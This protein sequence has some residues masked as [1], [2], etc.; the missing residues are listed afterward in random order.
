MSHIQYVD[1]LI[2]EYLLYRG[3]SGTVKMFDSELKVDKDKSFRV[4]KIVDQLTQ[5]IYAYDLTSLREL[6]SHLDQRMFSKLEHNFIPAVRKLEN[7]VLK[8]YL[9]N[10]VLSGKPD[11]VTEFFAR[12]T[13]ELIGQPEWKEWFILPWVKN[14]EEN[15]IF[16]MHFTRHWQDTL[17]VSLHNFLATIF[18]CMPQPMLVSFEEDALKMKKLQEENEILR[19]RVS[20]LLE[21]A[22]NNVNTVTDLPVPEVPQPPEL[23]D[24]FYVIALETGS[25]SG[26]SQ[27][28]TLKNLI[29]NI[30]SGLP[31]S[32]I[33]GRKASHQTSTGSRTSVKQRPSWSGSARVPSVDGGT[34]KSLTPEPP[35]R[36][37][38]DS[39]VDNPD[40]KLKNPQP[41]SCQEEYGEHRAPVCHCRFNTSGST[42]V[43]ADI[44][45]VVKLWTITPTPKTLA[46]FFSKS[47]IMALDWVT[48]NERYFIS[49]NK[50]GLVRLYDTRDNRMMWEMG[51]DAGSFLKDSRI[52]TICCSPVESTFICS[53]ALP[54]QGGGKLFLFD[55]KTKKLER[56]LSL[57]SA[58]NFA[59]ATCCTFNH[60]GQLLVTGCSDG[61]VRIFDLRRSD[62]IDSWTAHHGETLAIQLT[63]DFTSCYTLGQDSKLC[64]RSLNQSGQALWEAQLQDCPPLQNMTTPYGQLFAFDSPGSHVLTCGLSGGNIYQ[65]SG[66][67]LNRML[68]LG[69]HRSATFAV[70]WAIANQCATCITGSS[71]DGKIKV[72]TL[73]TP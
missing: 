13:P 61:V 30:G 52:M 55:I 37:P 39:S 73:L 41:I 66:S 72:S 65:I 16:Q 10:A 68:E 29:R 4:D 31:T 40:R 46:T 45:G 54:S 67:G 25:I 62:C 15:P 49:A 50:Q 26:E 20:T 27:V 42:V 43:S 63:S 14:P 17:L 18:Q 60:N 6:W 24:D 22:R 11:K 12:V 9:I 59:M 34:N 33:L 1:E 23:M 38:R 36:P 3:F 7:A 71:G 2:R 5:H 48:K 8:F 28:K 51:A 70:D 57:D 32:P 53:V 69:G 64:Q 35:P 44:D 19:M 21:N 58:Q 47:S 56:T